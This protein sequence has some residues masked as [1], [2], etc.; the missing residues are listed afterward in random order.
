MNATIPSEFAAFVRETAI[1]A[2]NRVAA[3]SKSLDKSL[4]RVLKSWTRLSEEKKNELFDALI[5]SA[6]GE[7]WA[8]EVK[9]PRKKKVAK[10]AAKTKK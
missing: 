10:K 5:A 1:R 3:K 4:Q 9:L 2:F 8:V 6:R 7:D